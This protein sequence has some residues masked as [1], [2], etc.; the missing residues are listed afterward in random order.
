MEMVLQ[1]KQEMTLRMTAELRQA[2]ELLQ[3][4][5]YDLELYIRQQELENPLIELK[6]REQETFQEK[7]FTRASSEPASEQWATQQK[8]STRDQFIK[9]VNMSTHEA[10][11]KKLLKTLI[12]NLDGNGYLCLET[13]SLPEEEIE[14]G[15]WLLQQIGPPGI[16]ARSLQECLLIQSAQCENRPKR[17]DE[18]IS[19]CLPLVADRKWKDIAKMM[20]SSLQ[21]VKELHEFILTLNPRPCPELTDTEI[22]FA[23]PDVIVTEKEGE[24]SFSLNDRA[25][26]QIGFR[27]EY[28]SSLNGQSE[29]ASY[30]RGCQKQA[31][32]LLSSI[33]QR[34]STIIRIVTDLLEKQQQFF[35][36]GREAL[37]PMTLKDIA[38]SI[39][40]HESTVSRAV[41]NKIMQTP[42]GTF[43]MRTL[44]TSKLSSGDGNDISQTA[45]K[46]KLKALVDREDKKKPLSDQKIA[47]Y[48]AAEQ[49]ITISRRTVSKYRDELQ[50]PSSSKR[51]EII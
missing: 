16:G 46:L 51:K 12:H 28:T 15:I 21:E 29:L 10:G 9:Q 27:S 25:L 44:F 31:Q 50:I 36:E 22:E 3:L 32:W 2:I 4:N 6:E 47:D 42:G 17:A 8:E 48:F 38:D 14:K 13:L 23:I 33:E 49:G 1:Q 34:R 35:F 41:S 26:P 5:T 24:L 40:M 45:V 37:K 43:E 39:D 11:T 30:L 7:V 18:F 20:N 19:S